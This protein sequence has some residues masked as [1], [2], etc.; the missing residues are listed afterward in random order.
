MEN[1]TDWNAYNYI[2]KTLTFPKLKGE[3][4]RLS[5]IVSELS[6]AKAVDYQ[7]ALLAF[8]NCIVI[9]TLK[10]QDRIKIRNEFIGE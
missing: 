1:R 8:I 10:L 3:R 5:L 9:S 4:Y 2:T 7:T 6:E